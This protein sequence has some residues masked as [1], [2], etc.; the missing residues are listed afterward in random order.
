MA[1]TSSAASILL[2]KPANKLGGKGQDHVPGIL[3]ISDIKV[4][5][6]PETAG[7]VGEEAILLN[8]VQRQQQVK[9]KPFL[10]IVATSGKALGLGFHSEE[11]RDE[12]L[13]LLKQRKGAGEPSGSLGSAE[14][15]A[16]FEANKDLEALYNQLVVTGILTEAEFW[17][18][19]GSSGGRLAPDTG[20]ASAKTGQRLGL[21]S[22]MH[23]VEKLHDGKTERV[24]IHLTSQDIQRIFRDKPEVN[25][26]FIAYVPHSMTE[27]AFWQKYFK[28]EYKQ[29]ARRRNIGG[30]REDDKDDIFAPFREHMDEEE[31]AMARA[32]LL[33][34]DPT[35]DLFSEYVGAR[36]SGGLRSMGADTLRSDEAI[37]P[38][39]AKLKSLANEL[40]R[41]SFHV[42]DGPI[43]DAADDGS[44]STVALAASLE[45]ARKKHA[46]VER[47]ALNDEE[48][49][50]QRALYKLRASSDLA[51]LRGKQA[52]RT[53]PLSINDDMAF[54][55][56]NRADGDGRSLRA[57]V[58]N[59][60]KGGARGAKDARD[61]GQDGD[62]EMKDD[63]PFS[64]DPLALVPV[65]YN[66]LYPEKALEEFCAMDSE[67][68]VKDFG[69]AGLS[70]ASISPEE[71]MGGVM[72]EFFRLEALKTDELLRHFWSNKLAPSGGDTEK[73]LRLRK[74]LTVQRESYV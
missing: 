57:K 40:N 10:R 12:V 39:T 4:L 44:M 67:R 63:S 32:R 43:G 24:N 47:D 61:G 52:E 6:K 13:E 23:E 5:W 48:V 46:T 18:K 38:A 45:A 8:D 56:I 62:V 36:W 30:I 7:A 27:E 66:M 20:G 28:L 69:T 72:V 17:S 29:A 19:H 64:V 65:P 55:Q 9:G 42:L 49:A 37:A 50:E 1:L 54:L 34:V 59:K 26:A 2:S 11:D 70:A 15:R 51:D 31:T 74:H 41:H 35:L 3:T 60:A 33:N 58:P 68:F 71:A 25:R 21:S 53:I 16:L 14:R 73:M 22:V